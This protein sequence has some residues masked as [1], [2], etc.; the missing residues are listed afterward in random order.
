[1]VE[2]LRILLRFDV[3]ILLV[4]RLDDDQRREARTLLRREFAS[5]RGDPDGLA[6]LL[7]G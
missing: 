4:D 2:S 7:E 5:L 1:M 3:G 6:S